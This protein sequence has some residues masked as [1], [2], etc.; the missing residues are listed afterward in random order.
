VGRQGPRQE[1]ARGVLDL[2]G[3]QRCAEIRLVSCDAQ[4]WIGDIVRL[5]CPDAIICLDAFHLVKWVTE[6]LDE[7]RRE[8]WNE[9]R[10]A[11]MLTHARDLKHARY[12]LWTNPEALTARQEAKLAWVAKV[13]GRLY[14]AYLLK[15]S[16]VRSSPSRDA[17]R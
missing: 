14:R 4:Q 17:E 3:E 7:V 9:A 16:S 2:L 6:A 10:R 8:T 5:R 13:N 12:A 15:S 1:D 11:G